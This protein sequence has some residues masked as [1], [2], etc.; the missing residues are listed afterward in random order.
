M[1]T[2]QQPQIERE[3]ILAYMMLNR[4]EGS[5]YPVLA[6]GGT[7]S[8]VKTTNALVITKDGAAVASLANADWTLAVPAGYAPGFASQVFVPSNLSQVGG[9]NSPWPT[10]LG[11]IPV[12][13][14][15]RYLA[16]TDGTTVYFLP[17]FIGL[18]SASAAPDAP[19]VPAGY[20]PVGDVTI[21]T[22][23]THTFTPGTTALSA[24]GITAAYRDFRWPD[25]GPSAFAAKVGFAA[26]ANVA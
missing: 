26:N 21:K 11:V 7:P 4:W 22:D 23:S 10:S 8:K 17:S 2:G 19:P 9:L 12:S 13:S 14:W 18:A 5:T 6:I 25:T 3:Q 1:A 16:V 24:T 15:Q 20:V